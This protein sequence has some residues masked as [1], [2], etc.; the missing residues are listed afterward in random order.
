[1]HR[2]NPTQIVSRFFD[3]S[4]HSLPITFYNRVTPDDADDLPSST[5]DTPYYP[6]KY[7]YDQSSDSVVSEKTEN[8]VT[9][10][11]WQSITTDE[12]KFDSTLSKTRVKAVW[13]SDISNWHYPKVFHP[14]FE[15][16]IWGRDS[17]DKPW[18]LYDKVADKAG[19][20]MSY[21]FSAAAPPAEIIVMIH[22]PNYPPTPNI[23]YNKPSCWH[24]L[25]GKSV[26][27]I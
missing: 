18:L 23:L 19:T 2:V 27:V 16:A 11:T 15:Y 22:N 12:Y 3:S 10:L 17:N 7:V 9:T 26:N 4:A 8:E 21:T 5:P 13:S 6:N 24:F 20:E 25:V 1:V 14:G